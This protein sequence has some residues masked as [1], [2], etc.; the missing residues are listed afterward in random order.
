MRSEFH[1]PDY[2]DLDIRFWERDLERYAGSLGFRKICCFSPEGNG[3]E[4]KGRGQNDLN[5]KREGKLVLFS[6][7]DIELL[8]R[9]CR[10]DVDMLLFPRFLP[11]AGLIRAVA[12]YKKPFEI[13]V[14]LLLH[15]SG[16]ERAFAMSRISFFLKLCNKHRAD[17]I[18]TSGASSRFLMKSP[19]ELISIGEMLGLSHDQAAKSISIIPEYVLER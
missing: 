6:S 16:S 8:K 19:A 2:Y 18:L 12:E 9:A 3:V 14:S 13:P 1:M 17:F 11:D 7:E 5:F 10:K 15:R 4:I